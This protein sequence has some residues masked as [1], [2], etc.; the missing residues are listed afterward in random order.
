M[1]T[2]N[3][4]IQTK[5][6]DEIDVQRRRKGSGPEGRAD[7]PVRRNDSGSSGGGGGGWQSGG[8]NMGGGNIPGGIKLPPWMMIVLVIIFLLCGGGGVLNSLFSSGSG[9]DTSVNEIP[10]SQN[11]VEAP[12][13]P[14]TQIPDSYT[15]QPVSKDGSTWTV[16]LYQ[17]ADDQ[18]LEQD[19][20]T[21][22]NEAE[23]IGSTDHVQIVS[24][25][26]RFRGG[27]TGDGNWSGARRYY[28]TKDDDLSHINSKML[29][30]LGEVNMSDPAVLV[31]FAEWAIKT[32]PADHY[33][34]ILSDHGM[35]WPG[36]WTDG[37][38]AD[39]VTP[40]GRAPLLRVMGN[41]L[42]SNQLD[43]ALK[44]IRDQTGIG[45][46]DIVG[47]DACLMGQ[48]EILSMLELHAKIAITSQETEPSLGWAYTSFLQSLTQSPTMSAT[49]L[50]KKVV[51]S[52]IVGD[53]RIVDDQARNEF[54]RQMGGSRATA[55]QVATEIG[56]DVT[57]SAIDLSKIPELMT[58]VNNLA[59]AM[60]N[61]DQ[62]V[63]AQARDYALSFT[64]IF[65]KQ[66]PP[67]YIDLGNF[68]QILKQQSSDGN[69]KNLADIILQGI[70][71][72][73]ISEKHGSGKKGA[74]GVAIYF[75]NSSLYRSP[76]SGPQSYT[77]IANQ[78]SE[79]SLW[80]DFLAYHYND[81]TFD[82]G[83]RAAIVPDASAPK[84]I[85]GAGLINIS[86]IKAS[87]SEAAPGQPVT[88]SAEIDGTN[89]GY[90]YLLIGYYDQASN[91]IFLADN[92]FLESPKT[93]QVDEV[94]YPVWNNNKPFKMNFKWDPTIFS[95]SD[96][97]KTTT[98][99]FSPQEY[100]ITAED[101]VYTVDGI[102]TFS[103]SGNKLNA[104]INFRNGQMVSVF[105]I[106]GKGDTGAPRQITPKAGDTFTLLNKWLNLNPDGSV[107]N[108]TI[109]EGETLTFGDKT[110]TWVEQYAAA[111]DYVV[112]FTVTDLDGNSKEAYTQVTVK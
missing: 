23:N 68:V 6:S 105:G 96:G 66:V 74:T 78:F 61:E 60:Q 81:R 108:T 47:M 48:L 85:P 1:F 90:I 4:N 45:K 110:F 84:R 87:S 16:M 67:A 18:I 14:S 28:V 42:Y 30:D 94:A 82:A 75:P 43:E 53:E 104:R 63:I 49:D 69:V 2:L 55:D 54:L 70:Q 101:A 13:N 7:A 25:L 103:E 112:G 65:G 89:I 31:D 77:V 79:Q 32:F 9:A 29:A 109:L 92:D 33:V 10:T 58:N 52:Y 57:L 36:G 19:I 15:P 83:S 37:D 50:A 39:S 59:Y 98:A 3:I 107:K 95:I 102:Y 24:Q 27:F 12:A 111:G 88:L 51:Q 93:Q 106:T 34:L 20:F 100:G 5:F 11:P 62:S 46:F 72:A 91:S 56:K 80:D 64:S 71:Q 97:Q 44:T 35:G 22:F 26:D 76:Y 21:D 17:D 99:L 73:V 8:N 40:S 86:N 38:T 41:A